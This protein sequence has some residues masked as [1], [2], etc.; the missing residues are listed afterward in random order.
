MKFIPE[1]YYGVEAYISIDAKLTL[2]RE[3]LSSSNL[4]I[5]SGSPDDVNM[6]SAGIMVR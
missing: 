3:Q 5:Q 1:R 4:W 2:A 6:I